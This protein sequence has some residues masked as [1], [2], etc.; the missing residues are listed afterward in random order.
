MMDNA[1][2]A[3]DN[4]IWR[5]A[6]RRICTLEGL[7]QDDPLHRDFHETLAAYEQL[8]TD[9]NGRTTKASRTRQKLKNKGVIQ[10]LEDWATSPA[11]TDGFE[12]LIT[13]G[14]HELTGEFLVLK[15]P[16]RFSSKAAETARSRLERAGVTQFPMG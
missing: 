5:R 7:N 9:K 8:L 3:G 1:K 16:S 15:Y 10:C 13:K 4:E 6:F 12:L 14:F 11:P 2:R